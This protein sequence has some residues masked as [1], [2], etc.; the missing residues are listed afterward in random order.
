MNSI[1][2]TLLK[3]MEIFKLVLP[4]IFIFFV[5]LLMFVPNGSKRKK[6]LVF[7]LIQIILNLVALIIAITNLTSEFRDAYN[8][9]F[10]I[11]SILISFVLFFF[12]IWRRWN[13]ARETIYG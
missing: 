13:I 12:I 10:S 11:S 7:L 2:K 1:L 3:K 5:L 8:L 4:L 9:G 6:I